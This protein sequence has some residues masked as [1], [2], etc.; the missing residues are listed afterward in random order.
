VYRLNR[1]AMDNVMVPNTFYIS[2]LRNPVKQFE[3]SFYYLEMHTLFGLKF[4]QNPL[5]EFIAKPE[6]FMSMITKSR[7]SPPENYGLYRNGMF[8]DLG[9]DELEL[10]RIGVSKAI[11]MVE[12]E[13]DLFLLLEYFDESLLLLKK[14]M[15]WSLENILYFKQNQRTTKVPID[16][17]SVTRIKKWNS[18]DMKLY[19]HF[20]Q[21]FWRKVGEYGQNFEEDLKELKYYLK[22]WTKRCDKREV[23]KGKDASAVRFFKVGHKAKEEDKEICERF[24]RTELE[25]LGHFRA[26][27]MQE[28]YKDYQKLQRKKL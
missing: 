15:C 17:V 24:F 16:T 1:V 7:K 13:I 5:Q 2:I 25:Y 18:A 27:F 11:E 10:K 12:K 8:F 28:Y 9:Y 4:S 22:Q 26:R 21:T 23:V 19:Q 20:N 3:S 14:A 6:E